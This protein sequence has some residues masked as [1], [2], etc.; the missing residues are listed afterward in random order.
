MFL[1]ARNQLE[2]WSL[3]TS[4]QTSVGFDW[5]QRYIVSKH[6]DWHKGKQKNNRDRARQKQKQEHSRV[7]IHCCVMDT[8]GFALHSLFCV[9]KNSQSLLWRAHY[10]CGKWKCK[11]QVTLRNDPMHTVGF[12][13]TRTIWPKC[14]VSCKQPTAPENHDEGYLTSWINLKKVI[15]VSCGEVLTLRKLSGGCLDWLFLEPNLVVFVPS[16]PVSFILKI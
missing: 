6:K 14:P 9:N 1:T 3:A 12:W 13:D 15:L 2:Y 16:K 5:T 7:K 4:L 8:S 11:K 10:M